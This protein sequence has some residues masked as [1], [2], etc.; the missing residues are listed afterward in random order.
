MLAMRWK[1]NANIKQENLHD[2][3]KIKPGKKKTPAS[4]FM[5]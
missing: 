4:L 2:D 5:S 3:N 1:K